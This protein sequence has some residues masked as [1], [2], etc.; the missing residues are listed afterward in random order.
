M[1]SR[2]TDLT[3]VQLRVVVERHALTV[4]RAIAGARGGVSHV[5]LR[6]N[7]LIH[8]TRLPNRCVDLNLWCL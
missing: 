6:V 5:I 2:V 7:D 3:R 1:S 8:Q 4:Q